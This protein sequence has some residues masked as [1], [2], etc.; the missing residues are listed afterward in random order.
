VL[1]VVPAA[2]QACEAEEPEKPEPAPVA[3]ARYRAIVEA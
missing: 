3:I 2:E 1:V